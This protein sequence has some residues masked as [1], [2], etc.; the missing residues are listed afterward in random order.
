MNSKVSVLDRAVRILHLEDN[1]LDRA[2]IRE[3]LEQ[4]GFATE[5]TLAGDRAEFLAALQHHPFDIILSDKSL[6][7]FDGLDALHLAKE[8]HPDLPFVFVSGSMG[9][10]AAIDTIKDG[11]TDYVL[12]DRLNR[13][14]P[15]VERAIREADQA[16]KN[17][18]ATAALRESEERFQLIARAS[19][20]VIW[21]WNIG[22]GSFWQSQGIRHF[23]YGDADIHLGQRPLLDHIQADQQERVLG[24]L[25]QVLQSREQYWSDEYPFLRKDGTLAH[26]FNR[27][28]VI[29]DAQGK[30]IRMVGAMMDVT[31]RKLAEQLTLERTGLAAL[32]A[33]VASASSGAGSLA[34]SL[35]QCSGAVA[36]HLNAA[37]VRIW[38]LDGAGKMLLLQASAG[39]LAQTNGI[40]HAIPVG[41]TRVGQ[42]AVA[43]KPIVNNVLSDDTH[44]GDCELARRENL[45][46]FGGY[47]LAGGKLAGVIAIYSHKPITDFGEEAMGVVSREIAL[48]I[49]RR[50]AGD[51]IREQAALLDQAQDA[52]FVP[53]LNQQIRYWNKSAERLYGWT[54]AEVLGRDVTHLLFKAESAAL[55]VAREA[56]LK[57]GE[58]SGEL[59]QVT[60]SGKEII[61]KSLWS[62]VR[63]PAGQPEAI[64]IV[65]TDITEKKK[66]EA[67]FLR[68][69]RLESIGALA[70]GIAHD[71]N[72]VLSPI[73]IG[74]PFLKEQIQNKSCLKILSAMESSA[75]RGAGIVKQV[76]TFARGAAEER[77]PLHPPQLINEIVKIIGETFPKSIQIKTDLER[78][79]WDI[80]GDPTQIHQVLLNLCVN[81]RDAMPK[82]GALTLTARNVTLHEPVSRAGLTG[83]TGPYVQIK[84]ID[85]GMGIP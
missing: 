8:L 53:S 74:V 27:G 49:E 7:G 41:V 64:L 13:L 15:A 42:V 45:P 84:V 50:Q 43:G 24:G 31:A 40:H 70:S 67:H 78:K 10:G 82:G 21:D 72:N 63:D 69:Q 23:G 14:I 73:L 48:G 22:S 32:R 12:K 81:A 16:Q 1:S 77:M 52:I 68:A 39:P 18:L 44:D 33:E 46:G 83:G 4:E 9:E 56:I 29:R 80:E 75:A 20:D 59:T 65:N 25:D 30:A 3:M 19:N 28:Y 36:R 57:Q 55:L 66:L 60:K 35:E 79:L 5:I 58:W 51:K 11:A 61:V 76:L 2:L 6:P 85:T 62:L 26:V 38:L 71:L 54:S 47:P 37:L 17:R 34:E